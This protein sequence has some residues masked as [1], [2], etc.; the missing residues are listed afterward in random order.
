MNDKIKSSF[1]GAATWMRVSAIVSLVLQSL[2]VLGSIN[3][4][5]N[6]GGTF[7]SI[8]LAILLLLSANSYS[9]Y[10]TTGSAT[11]LEDGLKKEGIYWQIC[12]ILLII[13]AILLS[14]FVLGLLVAGEQ[15]IEI[16]TAA[17]NEGMRRR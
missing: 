5:G 10:A 13:V 17:I 16:I 12:S 6:L 7:L 9:A 14:I 11:S 2:S 15:M 1:A 8:G 4:L 3:N